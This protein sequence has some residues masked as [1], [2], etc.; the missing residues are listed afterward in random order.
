MVSVKK[1]KRGAD[2]ASACGPVDSRVTGSSAGRSSIM[3]VEPRGN[4]TSRTAPE[5]PRAA[6]LV[7]PPA[8]RPAPVLGWGETGGGGLAG[9]AVGGVVG[10]VVRGADGAAG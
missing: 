3:T 1:L 5:S 9:S 6:A 4:P 10:P 8:A 2:T 7:A